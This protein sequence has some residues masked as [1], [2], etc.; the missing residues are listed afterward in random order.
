MNNKYFYGCLLDSHNS[1]WKCELFNNIYDAS[2]YTKNNN[3]SIIISKIVPI[4]YFFLL[5]PKSIQKKYLFNKINY[6][7]YLEN[8]S[9]NPPTQKFP[10]SFNNECYYFI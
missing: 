8:S 9:S 10:Y 3:K 4:N 1:C 5:L 6:P 2:E 7:V